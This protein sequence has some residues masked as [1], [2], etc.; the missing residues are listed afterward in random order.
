MFTKI[1]FFLIF[2]FLYHFQNAQ[3][4]DSKNKS[5]ANPKIRCSVDKIK[6]VP[7][8]HKLSDEQKEKISKRRLQQKFENIRIYLSTN[9]I[10]KQLTF[11][12]INAELI[13]NFIDYFRRTISYIEKIIKVE[14]L[15]Y[16][17]NIN[18]S[19][20][21]L[22]TDNN[23][24]E[25]VPYDL[26]VIPKVDL[27]SDSLSSTN[28]ERDEFNNRVI[29]SVI[30][31]PNDF[32]KINSKING[33]FYIESHLLHEF[34][35]ILGFLYDSFQYFP[36][37][38]NSVIGKYVS[39]SRERYYIKTPKVLELAKKYYGCPSIKGIELEDQE[40][41]GI[42]SSHWEA[43]ILL[44]EYMNLE[45]YTSEVVISDFTLA[46]LEDSGW[47]EVNHYTGGLMRFGKNKGCQFLEDECLNYQGITT[48]KNEFFDL[49]DMENPSCSSGRLG[50]AYN[51][52]TSYDSISI[53]QYNR[54][55]LDGWRNY[56]GNFINADYCFTFAQNINEESNN[57]YVGNCNIGNGN[58]G[59]KIIYKSN[60][61][62]KNS[63]NEKVLGE[64]YSSNSFCVLSEAYP[65]S[66]NLDNKFEGIIHPLCYEML[67]SST[68]LTIKIKEQFLVCPREGGKVELKGDFKGYIYCPDYNLICTGSV[69]CND[70][71]D[72][73]NK[74]SLSLE[75][76]YDYTVNG[77]TSSQ[78][79][80]AISTLDTVIGY[81][82]DEEKGI[83]PL[84][85][86]QCK[87]NKICFKCRTGY[88][89]IGQKENDGNPILCDNTININAGYFK[90]NEVN[91]PCIENCIT[92]DNSYTCIKCDQTHKLDENSICID[93]IAHCESY[94]NDDT[95]SKCR[96][97]YA[98]I[99]EDR[100]NCYKIENKEKYFSL[101]NG[102]SYYP[103]DT[104]IK[105]CDECQNKNDSCSKCFNSFYFLE[106]NRTYCFNNID[107]TNYYSPDN[108]ISFHLC[109][110]TISNCETCN[111]ENDSLNCSLCYKGY[112]FIETNR[113]ECFTG[114]DLSKYYS[115]DNNISFFPC[116]HSFP[117]CEI[118][119]NNKDVC[120]KCDDDYFFI[121][122]HKNK[123][124]KITDKDKY[125]TE[126]GGISYLPCD[127]DME[128]CE[129][130]KNR[131][132][133]TMCKNNYYF[134]EKQ[135][136]RCYKIDN[137]DHF[138]REG[139][140]YFYC[141][142]SI[143]N[144]NKCKTRDSCEECNT[145]FYF[146]GNDRKNCETDKDLNKYYSKDGGKSYFPCN[147]SMNYC[148][149]CYSE[150]YCYLCQS[151]YFLKVGNNRDCILETELEKDKT[152]YRLNSTHYKKCSETINN[153]VICSSKD[154]CDQC[155]SNYYFVDNNHT[156]CIN[157][158]NINIEEYYQYDQYNYHKCSWFINHCKKCNSSMCNFCYENFT[159]V[160]DNYQSCYPKENYQKGYYQNEKGNMY[161][162]C[163]DNCDKCVNG[164]ECLECSINYS[165]L[166]DGTSC[167][168]CMISEL[169]IRDALTEENKNKLIQSY[170]DNY[171]N[172][173]DVAMVYS[174]PNINYTLTI[175]RT[176]Q[177]TEVLFHDKYFSL[178]ISDF[179]ERLKRK[180]NKSGNSFVYAFLNYNYK[181]YFEIYDMETNRIID[182]PKECPE[183]VRVEYQIKNNYVSEISHVLGNKLSKII[184][185]NK[186]NVLNSTDSYFHDVCKTLQI[187]SIDMSIQQRRDILYL[188]NQLTK[189][190]C[191]DNDCN[192]I[193][194]LFNES[195]GICKCKFK[196]DFEELI[197][198][199]T[200]FE[201]NN[202]NNIIEGDPFDSISGI[203][204][205]PIFK[206]SKESFNSENIFSNVGLYIGII[207]V[208]IH[209]PSF[210]VLIVKYCIRKKIMKNI[211]AP[212]PKPRDFLTIKKKILVKDDT[213]KETQT[214]DR[215]YDSFYDNADTEK[216]VQ[217]RDESEFDEDSDYNNDPLN[218][219]VYKNTQILSEENSFSSDRKNDIILSHRKLNDFNLEK[220]NPDE[221][222]NNFS[223]LSEIKKKTMDELNDSS[224]T[225]KKSSNH[226]LNIS[227]D[228]IFCLIKDNKE[229][230]EL[231]YIILSKAIELDKRG[232]CELY[233]HLLALKQPIWDM[234]SDIKALQINRS[235]IP[236][237]M[238]IIRFVF[239]F[240]FNM[241]LNSLFLTQKYF[242]KKYNYFNNKYNIQYD[243]NSKSISSSEKFVYAI[244]NTIAFS[245]SV[246]IICLV[247]QFFMNYY[248]YN[249]RKQIWVILT[250]CDDDKKEEIKEMN[251]FFNSKNCFYIILAS[252]KF[253]LIIFFFFYIIN[254]SQAYKGGIIDYVGATFMTWLFLQVIPFISCLIF[255]LFRYYG[256]KKQDN[257]LYKLNQ[258]YIY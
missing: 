45:Q 202:N 75:A 112:Y 95:C 191:L 68:S 226:S 235:F 240:C 160:N 10:S 169:M 66:G 51:Q 177:C 197:S 2:N 164:E 233:T 65:S 82:S 13:N 8:I 232:I 90:K 18:L 188:G 228:E 131:T 192:L 132:Y 248:L 204:P 6:Y 212:P 147:T 199:D 76:N 168:S 94:N 84:N 48:F 144:C 227:E 64:T 163:I 73:I 223:K 39:R 24:L 173:Y 3:S 105:N 220:I 116:F 128:G 20:Y 208:I 109:N 219:N 103:C 211:A 137:F 32:L 120:T 89:L 145:N 133:C 87:N 121:G 170:I 193:S 34:T 244:K 78:K 258:V 118:C 203:N 50:R 224:N 27:I 100:E 102:V 151:S 98:F 245:V 107:L 54:I 200:F 47:Y 156:T 195:M 196:F 126:D 214:K 148:D 207:S 189:I 57:Y 111:Y 162:S 29:V 181:S 85:C 158:M 246:F 63:E 40:G 16:N 72:C 252:I 255:A 23:L 115:E 171:K 67:C 125:F 14:R 9:H 19:D 79:I 5:R 7:K 209:I 11:N 26:V 218:S 134:L 243:E 129:K 106:N 37:G 41:N 213:E 221:A 172:H 165:L 150:Y 110:K 236:L 62:Y 96:D 114:Y 138:Y 83:C 157:I 215:P 139:D 247:I 216:K 230:L 253:I 153:C 166:G 198:N 56:G 28:L 122:V 155:S 21:L 254:F 231:D 249:L 140:D 44:G 238:K 22:E 167:G 154:Y 186:I 86:G 25:G 80:S 201:E 97:E 206:C 12:G 38:I 46:L 69:L 149:E 1:L 113:K 184:Y 71:F 35:H 174:N 117:H 205:L 52:A 239:M 146:I 4:I 176:W 234:L 108:S 152:Y 190:T 36:N 61:K 58:Y 53:I 92:C 178:N 124:E 256:L 70:M 43:R 15:E 127:T 30:S 49:E 180:L 222:E 136:D 229:K 60:E 17:I 77:E 81:E 161:Y 59:S 237:S 91:Y 93:K 250:E 251:K 175:F 104:N 135:R 141:N 257:R 99:K 159:L 142:K 179:I 130:C 210:I 185:E 242:K 182:I 42:P 225:S 88:N 143:S 55:T 119:N 187:E 183:C 194:T 217:D 31:V 74:E 241:F 101:D 123:C 33:Q